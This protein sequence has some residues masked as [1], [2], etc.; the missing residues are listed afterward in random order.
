MT[1]T[2]CTKDPAAGRPVSVNTQNL[3]LIGI[4]VGVSI[5]VGI[6]VR[7]GVC[8][9]ICVGIGIRVGVCVGVC[10]CV[11]ICVGIGVRVRVR[12]GVSLCSAEDVLLFGFLRGFGHLLFIF[13]CFIVLRIN[14][15]LVNLNRVFGW[16]YIIR[17]RFSL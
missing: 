7:V 17:G 8:V 16:H 15:G 4:D 3:S 5:R 10:V 14:P 6:C 12:I 2:F 11:R 1:A 9:R 13:F